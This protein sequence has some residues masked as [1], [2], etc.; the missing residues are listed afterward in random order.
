L[1]SFTPLPYCN[2]LSSLNEAIEKLF[3]IVQDYVEAGLDIDLELIF[4]AGEKGITLESYN[5]LIDMIN[6]EI[7]FQSVTPGTVH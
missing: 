6:A 7:T 4:E 5:Q 1:N 3:G 2:D